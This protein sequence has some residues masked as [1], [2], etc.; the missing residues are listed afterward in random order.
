M[1]CALETARA[2]RLAGCFPTPLW[3]GVFFMLVGGAVAVHLWMLVSLGILRTPFLCWTDDP[4]Q[5]VPQFWH[6]NLAADQHIAWGMLILALLVLIHIIVAVWL[7]IL[8]GIAWIL[9]AWWQLGPLQSVAAWTVLPGSLLLV[10]GEGFRFWVLR[11]L[12]GQNTDTGSS[13][14]QP[15][16]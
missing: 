15:Q 1:S 6:D 8:V 14:S 16:R 9:G 12:R 2:R 4:Y 13:D 5:P 10:G 3:S 11:Q 7:W